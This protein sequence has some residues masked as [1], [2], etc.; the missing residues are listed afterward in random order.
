MAKLKALGSHLAILKPAIGYLQDEPV[1]R[2]A[3]RLIYSPWRKWYTT[4]RWRALRL[5]IFERD[6]YTCQRPECGRVEGNTSKLVADH[7][8]PHRGDEARFWDED[9]IW[10]LCKPCHDGWKQRLEQGGALDAIKTRP[11]PGRKF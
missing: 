6:G 9:G 4:P 7:R 5:R 11:P 8:E 2:D 1:S 10:T 3:R